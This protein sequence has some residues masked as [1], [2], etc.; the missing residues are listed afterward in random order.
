MRPK[1]LT[2]IQYIEEVT[3][4]ILDLPTMLVLRQHVC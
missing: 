1:I 3:M 2:K 4:K